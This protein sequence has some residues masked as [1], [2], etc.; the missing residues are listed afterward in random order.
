M[1][2]ACEMAIE[3]CTWGETCSGEPKACSE[4]AQGPECEQVDGCS[5]TE[6]P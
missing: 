5:W 2:M 4:I 6:D 3:E 1:P